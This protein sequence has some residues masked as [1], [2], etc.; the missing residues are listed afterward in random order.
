MEYTLV[1]SLKFKAWLGAG[2]TARSSEG[3]AVS[4]SVV[5]DSV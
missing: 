2:V 1:A 3:S 4:Q 5:I